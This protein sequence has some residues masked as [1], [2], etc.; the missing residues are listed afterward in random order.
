MLRVWRWGDPQMGEEVRRLAD[1]GGDE[2]FVVVGPAFDQVMFEFVCESL[3]R[4]WS[5]DWK[6]SNVVRFVDN[7]V[8]ML[9][10]TVCHA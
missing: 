1:R 2:D 6:A 7:G 3:E 5:N 10:W 9:L 8:V 4:R